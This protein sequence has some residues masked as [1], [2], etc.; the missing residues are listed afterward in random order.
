[1]YKHIHPFFKTVI[2]LKISLAE[3]LCISCWVLSLGPG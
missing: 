2:Y 3:A 1:M